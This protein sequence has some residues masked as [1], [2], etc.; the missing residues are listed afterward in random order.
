MSRNLV[1]LGTQVEDLAFV[2]ERVSRI[3]GL[4]LCE[5]S[6]ESYGDHFSESYLK[7]ID[8]FGKYRLA[9]GAQVS[10][11]LEVIPQRNSR[12]GTLTFWGMQDYAAGVLLSCITE[13]DSLVEKLLADRDLNLE[14]VDIE[15]D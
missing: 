2:A 12:Y 4:E 1:L 7:M 6:N 5:M 10:P 11:R 8:R 9:D 15:N 3:V 13:T 14:V